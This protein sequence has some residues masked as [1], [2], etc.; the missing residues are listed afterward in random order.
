MVAPTACKRTVSG[1][2]S[3]PC[4]GFFSPFPH[5]TCSLSVSQEYLALADGAAC[6]RQ[7][8]SGPALLRVPLR[9]VCLPVRAFHPLR[10]AFPDRSRSQTSTTSESYN[11]GGASTHPVWALPRS[12]ATT[13]GIIVIFSSCGYLDVSVPRVRPL[14]KRVTRSLVPGCPIRKSPDQRLFAP[15]RSLSQ[16]I[17]SFFASESQGIPHAL[18]VTFSNFLLVFFFSYA[19]RIYPVLMSS[20]FLPVC[21]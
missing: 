6:F 3:L 1:S 8:S 19:H 17:T 2:V 4:S 5:G 13:C 16:L 12:L 10:T 15:P 20:L 7:D 9:V 18:L 14:I 21:Q 11:P